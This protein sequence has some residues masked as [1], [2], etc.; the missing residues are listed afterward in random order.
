M[1]RLNQEAE[2]D[3]EDMC[4]GLVQQNEP[5][6]PAEVTEYNSYSI[7]FCLWWTEYKHK[8]IYNGKVKK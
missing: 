1:L 2:P 5:E 6:K 7:S 8:K 4:T 3:F